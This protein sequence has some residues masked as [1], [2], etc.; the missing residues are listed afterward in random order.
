MALQ[1]SGQIEMSEIAAELGESLSNV[2][3]GTMSDD[4][5]L[6]APDQMS[7]FYGYSHSSSSSFSSSKRGSTSN[8]ACGSLV[9]QTYYHNNGSGGSSTYVDVNDY[10]YFDSNMS[11]KLSSGYYQVAHPSFDWIRV[12]GFGRIY[13]TG[14]CD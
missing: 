4:A 1:S 9:N 3:L 5:G 12:N 8:T 14:F 7:D 2:S 10:V 6:S 13:Q 11:F